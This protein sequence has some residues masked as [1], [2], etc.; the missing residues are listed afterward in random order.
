MEKEWV[1]LSSLFSTLLSFLFADPFVYNQLVNLCNRNR[2]DVQHE[3]SRYRSRNTKG[4][5]AFFYFF[6]KSFVLKERTGI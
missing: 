5:S 4:P 3:R 2:G 6:S 1:S